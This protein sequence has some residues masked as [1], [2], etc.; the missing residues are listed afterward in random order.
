M[1]ARILIIEDDPASRELAGYLL[2]CAGHAVHAAHDGAE[3]LHAARAQIPDLIIC[4]LQMPV[5]N[6]FE[7]LAGLRAVP[8]LRAVR[9]IAV[10]AFSM[11][12]DRDKT[13][14]AGFEE[15]LSKPIDPYNFV[16]QIEALLPPHL[17]VGIGA[18]R[19]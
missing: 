16:A 10:T 5:M 13:L 6:G 18:A 17:R 14:A 4:D 19:R 11:S 8:E 1:A 2:S 9:V 3:G 7:F 15:Y 12:G